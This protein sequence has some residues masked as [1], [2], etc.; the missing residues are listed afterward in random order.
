M[1]LTARHTCRPIQSVLGA[2]KPGKAFLTEQEARSA[3]NPTLFQG[4]G[5]EFEAALRDSRQQLAHY[6][7]ATL[8][9]FVRG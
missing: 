5:R 2:A 4:F 3:G 9:A 6:I 8:A 7:K 1:R